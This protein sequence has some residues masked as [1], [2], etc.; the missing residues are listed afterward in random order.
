MDS[1]LVFLGIVT[2][3]VVL[4]VLVTLLLGIYGIGPTA[5]WWALR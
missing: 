3:L 1:V 4:A 2:V 5:A